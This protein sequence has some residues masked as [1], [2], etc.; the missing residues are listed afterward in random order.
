ML[1]AMMHQSDGWRLV[2]SRVPVLDS[3]NVIRGKSML[4]P[5]YCCCRMGV[6]REL[7]AVENAL[8]DNGPS[9]LPALPIVPPV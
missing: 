6:M 3:G 7:N 4:S 9:G 2:L 1:C 5:G 8:L